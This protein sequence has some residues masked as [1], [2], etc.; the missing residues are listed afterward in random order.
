TLRMMQGSHPFTPDRQHLHY[1]LLDQG[2]SLK[3]TLVTINLLCCVGIAFAFVGDMLGMSD[4]RL[5]VSIL[6]LMVIHFGLVYWLARSR[7]VN[8]S[9]RA[10]RRGR[11][12]VRADG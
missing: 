1:L 7:G 6:G 5:V 8:R 10:G 2:M 4:A 12:R 11:R 3:A 9:L